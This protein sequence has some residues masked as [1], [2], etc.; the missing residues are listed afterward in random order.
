MQQSLS[1]SSATCRGKNV[2]SGWK[3]P[4]PQVF[5][6]PT[7]SQVSGHI[8]WFQRSQ[9][10]QSGLLF[11]PQSSRTWSLTASNLTSS[12]RSTPNCFRMRKLS[13]YGGNG[14]SPWFTALNIQHKVSESLLL[15]KSA[16]WDVEGTLFTPSTDGRMA[17]RR[18]IRDTK[19]NIVLEAELRFIIVILDDSLSMKI[20]PY[21]LCSKCLRGQRM[22]M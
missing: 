4:Q 10:D 1:F 12:A 14:M 18:L 20:K 16:G 5:T 3:F 17:S 9:F 8:F 15:G 13:M 21:L 22:Q 7:Q 19:R 11:P 2:K 6:S